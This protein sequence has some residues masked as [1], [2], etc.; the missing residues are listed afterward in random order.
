[1][2]TSQTNGVGGTDYTFTLSDR[3]A[4]DDCMWY[5]DFN[6]IGNGKIYWTAMTFTAAGTT[7]GIIP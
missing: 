2:R 7:C 3:T 1:M 5:L 6:G 4:P